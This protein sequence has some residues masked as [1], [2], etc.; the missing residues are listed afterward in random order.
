[1]ILSPTCEKQVLKSLKILIFLQ[2]CPKISIFCP[3]MSHKAPRGTLGPPGWQKLFFRVV[4]IWK[5]HDRKRSV[6]IISYRKKLVP[7]DHFEFGAFLRSPHKKLGWHH[8]DTIQLY[9][10]YFLEV[11]GKHEVVC[12]SSCLCPAGRV[13]STLRPTIKGFSFKV[14]CTFFNMCLTI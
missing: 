1:M 12:Q 8:R 3:K 9:Y 10:H 2:I 4:T 14:N 6:W 13:H 11:Y 5:P 7:G